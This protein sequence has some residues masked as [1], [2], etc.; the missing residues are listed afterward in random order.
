MAL[1]IAQMEAAL[2]ED[3]NTHIHPDATP[4]E[5]PGNDGEDVE[6][7]EHEVKQPSNKTEMNTEFE[8]DNDYDGH[9]DRNTPDDLYSQKDLYSNENEPADTDKIKV[10]GDSYITPSE[11]CK[12]RSSKRSPH[13]TFKRSRPVISDDES[14]SDEENAGGADEI[15]GS[16]T[17]M[18]TKASPVDCLFRSQLEIPGVTTYGSDSDIS[19][20]EDP[21]IFPASPRSPSPPP[22]LSQSAR[23]A[24]LANLPESI[25]AVS[26]LAEKIKSQRRS[27][28]NLSPP[29]GKGRSL[30]RSSIADGPAERSWM[31]IMSD[32]D[33]LDEEEYRTSSLKRSRNVMLQKARSVPERQ[34]SGWKS[35][36]LEMQTNKHAQNKI[37]APSTLESGTNNTPV[38]KSKQP[39]QAVV[40]SRRSL[41]HSKQR[42]DRFQQ[43]A[44]SV[45]RKK[46]SL[47]RGEDR[48]D[49]TG[50]DHLPKRGDRHRVESPEER[51]PSPVIGRSC[52]TTPVARKTKP[53]SL[54]AT[55]LNRQDM[56][57]NISVTFF[58]SNYLNFNLDGLSKLLLG[59]CSGETSTAL[60]SVE[61]CPR[62]L[63]PLNKSIK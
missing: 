46:H 53:I 45:S 57:S 37:T 3:T 18:Q 28:G 22:A 8:N 12:G 32:T 42:D 35:K 55:G 34:T 39:G 41:Y 26:R 4:V 1:E 47:Q 30:N 44:Q 48:D 13:L 61:T 50:S 56:V 10:I 24:S 59:Y 21:H 54:V 14:D 38:R 40:D 62:L 52:H 60:K 31:Q 20:E 23:R 16:E 51:S 6:V 36:S 2:E 58:S 11:G 25:L 33:L 29:R 63:F 15:E 17:N 27:T 9:D 5:H 49:R 19:E 43:G 7:E